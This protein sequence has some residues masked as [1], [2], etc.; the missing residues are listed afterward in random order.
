MAICVNIT[1]ILIILSYL[2]PQLRKL[3]ITVIC[4]GKEEA[5][6]YLLLVITA[7]YNIYL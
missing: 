6:S 7:E 1:S 4:I 3:Y 2:Y 5:L